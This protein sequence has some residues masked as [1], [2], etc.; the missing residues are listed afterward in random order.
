MF[1]ERFLDSPPYTKIFW[2][3][4]RGGGRIKI[5]LLGTH[6]QYDFFHGCQHVQTGFALW[7]MHK[8]RKP[9]LKWMWFVKPR[10]MCCSLKRKEM[11]LISLSLSVCPQIETS[12]SLQS[13][14]GVSVRKGVKKPSAPSEI[15]DFWARKQLTHPVTIQLVYLVIPNSRARHGEPYSKRKGKR[16]EYESQISVMKAMTSLH[17]MGSPKPAY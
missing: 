10:Q 8:V 3:T 14:K 2:L 15:D 4:V 9:A 16:R 13:P 11:H 1:W 5:M 17:T 7:Q 12:T 6:T